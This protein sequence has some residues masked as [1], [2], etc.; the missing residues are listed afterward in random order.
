ME[1]KRG[2]KIFTILIGIAAVLFA[3]FAF[4]T[5]RTN[6]NVITG[7]VETIKTL[8]SGSFGD[9][10]ATMQQSISKIYNIALIELAVLIAAIIS[11]II[12][13]SAPHVYKSTEP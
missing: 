7:V 4:I 11:T 9:A 12:R 10:I 6:V 1:K 13:T 5:V 2:L 3:I 8:V